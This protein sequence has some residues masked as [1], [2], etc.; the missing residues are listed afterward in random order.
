MDRP[1]FIN[2]VLGLETAT[3]ARSS[4]VVRET[5]CG[6]IGV[7]FMHIQGPEE[8]AWIQERI[9]G[10]ATRPNFTDKGKEA[11]LAH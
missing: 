3:C 10:G 2:Y 7:E 8:K 4:T 6:N 1:I 5:Y 11:I 9:E